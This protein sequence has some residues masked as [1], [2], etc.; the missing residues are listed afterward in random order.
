MSESVSDVGTYVSESD[1]TFIIRTR[2]FPLY[3]TDPV[4]DSTHTAAWREFFCYSVFFLPLT[5]RRLCVLTNAHTYLR[6]TATG[7]TP[8]TVS[9]LLPPVIYRLYE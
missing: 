6:Y 8:L 2:R 5:Q 3:P 9:I 1:L 7:Q 4:E